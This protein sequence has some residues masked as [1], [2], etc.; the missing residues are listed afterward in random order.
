MSAKIEIFNK[1]DLQYLSASDFLCLKAVH[2]LLRIVEGKRS[3]ALGRYGT[4][5]RTLKKRLEF[6]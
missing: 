6:E 2:G 1:K 4:N 3:I 5:K